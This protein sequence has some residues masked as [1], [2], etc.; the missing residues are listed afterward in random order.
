MPPLLYPT[1]FHID[2][3]IYLFKKREWWVSDH[4][5]GHV[6]VYVCV[7]YTRI[8]NKYVCMCI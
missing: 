2:C 1:Y 6:K 3:A 8:Y 5:Y 4:I 7:H